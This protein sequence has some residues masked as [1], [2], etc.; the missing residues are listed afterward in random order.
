MSLTRVP[1]PTFYKTVCRIYSRGA[2]LWAIYTLLFLLHTCLYLHAIVY[3]THTQ[4]AAPC[5]T[6][7]YLIVFS[8]GFSFVLLYLPTKI[9][10][11]HTWR[12]RAP[13]SIRYAFLPFSPACMNILPVRVSTGN[14]APGACSMLTDRQGRKWVV[15]VARIL[16]RR[17]T[18]FGFWFGQTFGTAVLRHGGGGR[19]QLG[20]L[21]SLLFSS[22]SVILTDEYVCILSVTW[23]AFYIV[24]LQV[25]LMFLVPVLCPLPTPLPLLPPT[26]IAH[27]SGS[28][29]LYLFAFLLYLPPSQ[30]RIRGTKQGHETGG[31]WCLPHRQP[32]FCF[33]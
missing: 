27:Y 13:S 8:G 20:S 25:S 26:P 33:L 19:G 17:L 10:I 23:L 4:H 31:T 21:F 7:L 18:A 24:S 32:L 9:F 2:P 5:F 15:D 30:G 22:S 28:T 3:A 1:L 16:N 12:A 14:G 29:L 6:F 11:L